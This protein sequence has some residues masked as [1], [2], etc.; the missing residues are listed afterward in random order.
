MSG[1]IVLKNYNE[2][3]IELFTDVTIFMG[4]SNSHHILEEAP[5]YKF[6]F[7]EIAT[8]EEPMPPVYTEV[9]TLPAFQLSLRWEIGMVNKVLSFAYKL[10]EITDPNDD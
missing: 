3:D 6:T 2:I 8:Y 10:P 4:A 9:E 7:E 5:V 1:K